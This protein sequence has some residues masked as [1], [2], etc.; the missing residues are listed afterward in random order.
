ASAALIN[1]AFD[2]A[3]TVAGK[4]LWRYL[5]DLSPEQTVDLVDWRYLTDALTPAEALDLLGAVAAGK[6]DRARALQRNGYP[7]YTTTPGWLG[8][9]DEKLV[10][11]AREAVDDGFGQIKLKVGFDLEHDVRRMALAREAVGPGI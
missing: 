1:A 7:A 11:L 6:E 3:A 10:R 4:P 9:T 5:S 2:L 8:Y